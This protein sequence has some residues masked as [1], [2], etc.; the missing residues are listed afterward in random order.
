MSDYADVL[1]FLA[2]FAGC[3]VEF[4]A[5]T[6]FEALVAL[7]LNVGEMYEDI[8]TLLTRDK[9]KSLVSVEKLHSALC[10]KYSILCTI[11]QPL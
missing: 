10:H 5:L 4:D 8:I 2:L 3:R 7:A 9:T 1:G 11:D 6:L